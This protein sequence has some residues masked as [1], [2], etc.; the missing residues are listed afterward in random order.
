MTVAIL[1]PWRASDDSWRTESFT[2][3][4]ARWRAMVSGAS[5]VHGS[6]PDGPFNRSLAINNARRQVTSSPSVLVIADADTHG[7]ITTIM[8]AINR[9]YEDKSSPWILP[10][11][12]YYNLTDSST[13]A[14]LAM[15]PDSH[16][17]EGSLV[18]EHRITSPPMPPYGD[19]V[20]G[21]LVMPVAA[22]DFVGGFDE[23]FAGWGYEDKDMAR[24]L[25]RAWGVRERLDGF[26]FHLWHPVAVDPFSL[27]ES[28]QN[29]E[30]YRKKMSEDVRRVS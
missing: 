28:K 27:P 8:R 17:S 26:V 18:F 5:V 1:I 15:E 23:D 25:D 12:R 21:I 11:T 3:C 7:D 19:P 10:Y 29:E 6:C 22:Y 16:I 20:S 30:L 4:V 24:R 14:I 13:E 9:C 2:W